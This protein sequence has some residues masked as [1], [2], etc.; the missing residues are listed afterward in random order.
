MTP[1]GAQPKVECRPNR[2]SLTGMHRR[3]F[4]VALAV[5]PFAAAQES[6]PT[7]AEVLA[8]V[9]QSYA[10][11]DHRMTGRLRDSTSGREEALELMEKI[12]AKIGEM[13]TPITGKDGRC[14][15]CQQWR[16]NVAG[17]ANHENKEVDR[18]E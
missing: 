7:A 5:A 3:L 15:T 12:Q 2:G 1:V 18:G 16:C 11:Q 6:T 14:P 10:L 4:L 17:C 13:A 9:R 8:R